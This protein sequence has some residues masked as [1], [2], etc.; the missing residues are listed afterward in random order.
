[1]EDSKKS[2]SK[3]SKE[4]REEIIKKILEEKKTTLEV[5]KKSIIGCLRVLN[6]RINL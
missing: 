3:I 4:V 1:M 6:F 2:Y 5:F